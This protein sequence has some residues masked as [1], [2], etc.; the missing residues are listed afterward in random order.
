VLTGVSRKGRRGQRNRQCGEKLDPPCKWQ[1]SIQHASA[2]EMRMGWM[3]LSDIGKSA[4]SA[5]RPGQARYARRTSTNNGCAGTV[6]Q[7]PAGDLILPGE[8]DILFVFGVGQK[9]VEDSHPARVAGDAV[10]QAYHHHAPPLRA[11]L[12]K[13]VKF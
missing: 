2:P 13:L 6:I 11:L 4:S 8:P 1:G 10:V 3:G 7:R 12:V 9:A 5:C